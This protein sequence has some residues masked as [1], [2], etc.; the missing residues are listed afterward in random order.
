MRREA[1]KIVKKIIDEM[2]QDNDTNY[3]PTVEQ[4]AVMWYLVDKM[5]REGFIFS[6][7]ACSDIAS[8]EELEVFEK[9]NI[10]YQHFED[11]YN[12]VSDVFNTSQQSPD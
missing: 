7:E 3:Y 8:G 10:K 6:A 2:G 1:K 12:L 5:I 4:N 11:L 9:Y